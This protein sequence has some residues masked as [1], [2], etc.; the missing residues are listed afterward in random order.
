MAELLLKSFAA[1]ILICILMYLMLH[2]LKYISKYTGHKFSYSKR[3][4][5]VQIN[6]V[7]YLDSNSRVVNFKCKNRNYIVLLGK[8]ND[9][10][11]DFYDS[12]K[13]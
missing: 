5:Q 7:T 1:L 6:A 11:I 12:E 9:L 3:E 2:L 4:G 13:H 8:N 10:L